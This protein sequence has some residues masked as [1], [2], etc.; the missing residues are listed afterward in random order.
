MPLARLVL[1]IACE[2]LLM[3]EA[4]S[5]SFGCRELSTAIAT[6]IHDESV[7]KSEMLDDLV[8]TAF[9]DLIGEAADVEVADVIVE[10]T[11]LGDGGDVVVGTEV[12]ALQ[13]VAE[14]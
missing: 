13:G 2:R 10:D 4:G 7:A 12:T 11:V 1:H 14:V 3:T 8:E 5:K 9:A 6:D